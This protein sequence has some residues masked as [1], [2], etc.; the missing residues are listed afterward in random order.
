MGIWL[1]LEMAGPVQGLFGQLAS[2]VL[3]AST[4]ISA[5][6]SQYALHDFPSAGLVNVRNVTCWH[7]AGIF[8]DFCDPSDGRRR[9]EDGSML[10]TATEDVG[11]FGKN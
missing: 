5:L 2:V 1:A 9:Q 6:D 7:E 3:W 4:E 8:F 11:H 10:R